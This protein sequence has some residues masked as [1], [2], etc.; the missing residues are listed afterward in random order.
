VLLATDSGSKGRWLCIPD[1]M[2]AR[3][4]YVEGDGGMGMNNSHKIGIFTCHSLFSCFV[5]IFN[6]TFLSNFFKFSFWPFDSFPYVFH[7]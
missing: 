6:E 2:W 5:L 3:E 4:M 7:G 1:F